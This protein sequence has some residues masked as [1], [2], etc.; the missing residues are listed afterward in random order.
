[1]EAFQVD[2]CGES[3]PKFLFQISRGNN[4]SK[5]IVSEYLDNEY[6]IIEEFI[7][8]NGDCV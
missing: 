7:K 3:I 6:K 5:G 1:M 4:L 8:A 2:G